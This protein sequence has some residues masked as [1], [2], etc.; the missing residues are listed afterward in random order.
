M[1]VE[2]I[3]QMYDQHTLLIMK[4]VLSES[5]SC[6]DVG[7]HVGEVLLE[8]I[9]AAPKGVHYAFEPIP[10]LFEGL[11]SNQDFR[12]VE[13]SDFALSDESGDQ[14][15][16]WVKNDPAY[17]GLKQRRYDRPDP[18]VVEIT[19]KKARL[20]D[21]IPKSQGIDFIKIDVEGGE[22]PVL[23]GAKRIIT[24]S[25]PYIVF[26]SGKGASD[27]YGTDGGALFDYL[28][29][30]CG[31]ELNTLDGFLTGSPALGRESLI[32][33]FDKTDRYYFIAHRSLSDAERMMH[34]RL[35]A[36]NLDSRLFEMEN[37]RHQLKRYEQALFQL[38]NL[39]P[40][41]VIKDWGAK[42]TKKGQA[43]NLQPDGSSA[44]W[45][46]ASNVSKL[47]DVLF[48]FG[49]HRAAPATLNDDLITSEIPKIV[50]QTS[51]KYQVRILESSGRQTV[52]GTFVVTS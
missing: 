1:R 49:A 6:I 25:K 50:I 4:I 44:L 35:Y 20:D 47:G 5:S 15:F 28:V 26:E 46:R 30:E 40:D 18:E 19:V 7:A 31:L 29:T 43:V 8:M 38:Q 22:L 14:T 51:G 21:V 52:V 45:V 13:I 42:E 36:L 39:L 2:N 9:S 37:I 27:R 11:R 24:E 33:I 17:S 10:Y 41:V 16:Y 34:L 3:H 48:E 32:Q 12:A 23:R